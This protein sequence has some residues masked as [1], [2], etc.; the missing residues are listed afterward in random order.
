[1]SRDKHFAAPML[2][3]PED[4]LKWFDRYASDLVTFVEHA[5]LSHRDARATVMLVESYLHEV[6]GVL[7]KQAEI[8]KQFIEVYCLPKNASADG[9]GRQ[10]RVGRSLATAPEFDKKALAAEGWMTCSAECRQGRTSFGRIKSRAD[11]SN[12][13]ARTSRGLPF[14]TIV[15]GWRTFRKVFH[16]WRQPCL[17]GARPAA[18]M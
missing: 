13:A 14:K 8:N 6:R 17:T 9:D 16:L 5:G 4:R 12:H 3:S 11:S 15:A 10:L 18:R 2:L 7:F 1:L